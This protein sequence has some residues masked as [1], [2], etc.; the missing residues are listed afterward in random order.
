MK[1]R[2]TGVLG[3][4]TAWL[5]CHWRL[6]RVVSNWARVTWSFGGHKREVL[7]RRSQRSP[8]EE[9][10]TPSRWE[11]AKGTGKDRGTAVGDLI[12]DSCLVREEGPGML[13]VLAYVR[14]EPEGPG[15]EGILLLKQT[16]SVYWESEVQRSPN[17]TIHFFS[18]PFS[19]WL[20]CFL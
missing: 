20:S 12:Q 13:T 14:N 4:K 10:S 16:Q 19:I 11:K 6:Q 7:P 15:L 5:S 1:P 8:W 9:T 18:F 2:P 17:K 3:V